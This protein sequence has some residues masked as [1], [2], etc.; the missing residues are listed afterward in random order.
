MEAE[1]RGR[2]TKKTLEI[3]SFQA[4]TVRLI[5]RLACEGDGATGPMGVKKI[6]KHLNAAGF[7][8]GM[9]DAGASVLSTRC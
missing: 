3:D 6:T 4:E 2:R 1:Q 9:A 7:A 5:F 8:Q